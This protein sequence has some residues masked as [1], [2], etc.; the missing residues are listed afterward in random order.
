MAR[1]TSRFSYANVMSTVAVFI[2]LGGVSYAA[3][4]LPSNSV[5]SKQIKKRAVKNSDLGRSAVTTGK[6]KNF[7]LL[8]KDFKPGQLPQGPTGAPGPKGDTGAP[9][10]NG[11]NGTNG[12][13]LAY[14]RVNGQDTTFSA[15]KGLG[16]ATITKG[17]GAG[18]YCV[19]GLPFAPQ[20]VSATNTIFGGAGATFVAAD[21]GTGSVLTGC[22]DNTQVSFLTRDVNGANADASFYFALN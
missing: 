22:P 12:S 19:T 15:T 1:L 13:A 3:I 20:N 7:S 17:T 14:G 21:I 18:K 4:T 10:T 2:A 8:S 16:S 11:T 9:G 5:G 6:V